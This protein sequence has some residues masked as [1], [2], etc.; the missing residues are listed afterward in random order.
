[1]QRTPGST[2][3]ALFCRAG[4][5]ILYMVNIQNVFYQIAFCKNKNIQKSL[6][7]FR[8]ANLNLAYL[9]LA[10][11]NLNFR[12]VKVQVQVRPLNLAKLKPLTTRMLCCCCRFVLVSVAKRGA[13]FG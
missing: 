4:R 8:L 10:Y 2:E 1:M 12:F 11:L 5:K 13:P 3:A 7:N 9:N 6:A